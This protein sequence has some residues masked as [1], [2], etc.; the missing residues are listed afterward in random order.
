MRACPRFPCAPKPAG[1]PAA[2]LFP[3]DTVPGNAGPQ[4]PSGQLC[5]ARWWAT[6]HQLRTLPLLW[7]PHMTHCCP[8]HFCSWTPLQ[9][10]E[11]PGSP[12]MLVPVMCNQFLNQISGVLALAL[13]SRLL[14]PTAFTSY[15]YYYNFYHYFI[16]IPPSSQNSR[17]IAQPHQGG[18]L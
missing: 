5:W 7:G 16:C 15:Y 4:Q 3:F 10:V 18:W 6:T 2:V 9:H 13:Q 14:N 11:P 12:A 1:T 17:R 8:R